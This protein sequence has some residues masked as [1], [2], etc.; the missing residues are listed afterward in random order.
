VAC[1]LPGLCYGQYT[2]KEA[3]ISC[4]IYFGLA[5]FFI[6]SG[7]SMFTH[8]ELLLNKFGVRFWIT[9]TFGR[10]VDASNEIFCCPWNPESEV[11]FI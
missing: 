1:A 3:H 5:F 6:T 8:D 11:T 2:D 7:A 4:K 10:G 9:V